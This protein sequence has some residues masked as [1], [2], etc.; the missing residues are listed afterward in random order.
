MGFTV[1]QE[2]AVNYRESKSAAVSASAGSGKTSVLVEHIARLISDMEDPVPA[3]RIAAV[4]FTEKA[5]AELKQRLDARISDLM[6][7]T[8]GENGEYADFLREQSV[9]LSSAKIS[10]I[11]SFCLS[12]VRENIRLLPQLDEGFAV[13]DE[14]EM[15][16]LSEK[17][18]NSALRRM[19]REF[20]AEEKTAVSR[21]IGGEREIEAAVLRL[22]DFLSNIPSPEEWVE[23][24][25]EI[26][27]DPDLYDKYFCQP[28]RDMAAGFLNESKKLLD[29]AKKLCSEAQKPF[30]EK[31]AAY[32]DAR[33]TMTDD[34]L[35]AMKK[36]DGEKMLSA[37]KTPPG[38]YPSSKD[39]KG[40]LY[41]ELK[42]I[43]EEIKEN[44]D[45][46]L[47]YIQTL[48]SAAEDAAYCKGA[49][50]L[51]YRI[52]QL[53]DEEYSL[54][55]RERN[56]ADF[57]DMERFA[58]EAVR[59]GGSVGDHAFIIVDEFQDSNDIQFEI[60]RLL[61][62]NEENL[63]FV[64]DVKQCIYSFRNA[65]PEIFASLLKNDNYEKFLLN[66][67]FRSSDDVINTVNLM[68]GGKM[69]HSFDGG[70]WEPMTAGR[71]IPESPQNKT[72][73]VIIN[74]L[75]EDKGRE[76]L[77][78]AGRIK[79][80][81]ES[82][83]TIHGRD[84]ERPCNYGDFA[85]LTRTSSKTFKFR[86]AFE[87]AGI[88][89][90]AVGDKAFTDLTEIEI[91]LALLGAVLKPSDDE[92]VMKA[93]MSPVYGFS[94]EEAAKVRLGE[95]TELEDPQRNTLYGNLSA[96]EKAGSLPQKGLRFLK[97]M[98]LL[99]KQAAN[100]VCEALIREIY[101]VTRLPQLMSVGIN[102]RERN[103]NLRLLLH[104]AKA[105]PRPADFAEKMERI[106]RSRLE[107]PQAQ[108][109]GAESSVTMMT[110]HKSK[111]LQFPIVFLSDT[112][113]KTDA[114]DYSLP[115]IFDRKYGAGIMAVDRYKPVKCV[116]ASHLLL[117]DSLADKVNGE[118]ARLLYV[119]MT[120]AEEKL[121]VTAE[122]KVKPDKEGYIDENAV[123]ITV[124][125]NY[126]DMIT[127]R[128]EEAPQM[129]S[130]THISSDTDVSP[131]KAE[132]TE[133]EK[134]LPDLSELQKRLCFTYPYQ[135]AA[136]TPAKF[137]ATALGVAAGDGDSGDN[138]SGAFYMGLPLFMKKDRPLTPK[139]RGDVYHK[140]M[141]F[142][143]FSAQSAENELSRLFS[144]GYLNEA[145]KKAVDISEIQA[146]L[147]S[148]LAKRAAASEN[149]QREFP[150][151]TTVNMTG[152]ENPDN[153][154]L[155]FVQGVADMFFEEEGKLVL[156]DYKTNRH[157]T[158]EKLIQEYKGQ[159]EIYKKALEEM[160]G[161]EVKECELFSFT[162]KKQ[163]AIYS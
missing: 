109:A 118:E 19:Y 100:D 50:Q 2:N 33:L 36:M 3:D 136:E 146:F 47:Q 12:I 21:K 38:R 17:A 163:I 150:L 40:A 68:F 155:S 140:V 59:K 45:N 73:L 125:G 54:L 95:G 86:K 84:G 130:L 154:D 119:A 67:N 18:V 101:S 69:P 23:R 80:M 10:T 81:V 41:D 48:P 35:S 5:A 132:Q 51:L 87:D 139:E 62:K 160:T 34:L 161:K 79:E 43:K 82:G 37:L 123:Q 53:Y 120:R 93:L 32:F 94:A 76:P 144:E 14:T 8:E 78:V 122:C 116:T 96:M 153:D 61:S 56:V 159:L 58:L 71:G 39:A 107:M 89:Y 137:T 149:V 117:R 121:I 147:D 134:F 6:E 114:R 90:T 143:D 128:L 106:K 103:E 98:R 151:F 105:T 49:F 97:D 20:S 111:G 7:E 27:G 92:A 112:N 157:T 4:T 108:Q 52:E 11:S 9:R 158:S 102:G 127:K 72:E 83:F 25:L 145:E 104:Y 63:Y 57:A 26:Y 113:L 70:S 28:A 74:S 75:K 88:P 22:Y 13:G 30:N 135:K 24:Q 85:V 66:K 15:K 152:E 99:R 29:E 126:L 148:P 138:V 141:Q 91:A 65:N 133:R 129:L 162:L 44:T 55:K 142:I 16:M 156:V 1:E 46:A 131:Q 124:K 77:Y 64:G 42:E 115:F 60:F 31:L 110:I